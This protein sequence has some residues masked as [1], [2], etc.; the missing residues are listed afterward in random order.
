MVLS[1]EY[2]PRLDAL[3]VYRIRSV[4]LRQY[5][6]SLDTPP[7]PLRHP[8]QHAPG[9]VGNSSHIS[10][11]VDPLQIQIPQHYSHVS[12]QG[13]PH[14][15]ERQGFRNPISSFAFIEDLGGTHW[16]WSAHTSENT[17][18]IET[19]RLVRGLTH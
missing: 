8:H 1:T 13:Q 4:L 5:L 11:G 6:I 2:R 14:Q 19:E 16:S 12:S 18:G 17:F 15:T 10:V 9:A 7:A 3:Q